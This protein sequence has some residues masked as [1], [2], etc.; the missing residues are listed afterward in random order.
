LVRRLIVNADDLGLHP[1]IN[2][3]VL[4]AH[5]DGIVT[6][7]SLS[8]N[9]AA[10]DDALRLIRGAPELSVGIHLTLVGEAALA[11]PLPSLAPSGRLP[12]HFTALFRLL[13]LGR[14]REEEIERELTAQVARAVDSGVR[15]SHVDGHQHVHLHPVL[16]PIVL[17][18]ARR[19]G[20]AA[21]RAPV[22]VFPLR[23]LRPALL[24]FV[25]RR[26]ARRAREAG[27][28]GPDACLGLAES[29]RLNERRLLA[30]VDGLPEGTTEIVCHPGLDGV[31]IGEA[32]PWGF[33]W[34]DETAALTSPHVRDALRRRDVRLVSYREL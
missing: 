33:L 1:G 14:V 6:S 5:R 29:G 16:L 2:A 23:G 26:A 13:L 11:G 17:R 3:G 31:T 24:W 4:R 25:A 12:A 34:D 21:V 27:L 30:L 20:I 7:A 32:Y 10:F 18:V 9:G 28:R 22:E 8:P 19:F 15:A